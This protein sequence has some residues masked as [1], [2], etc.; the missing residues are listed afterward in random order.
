MDRDSSCAEAGEE[1]H[2]GRIDWWTV[3]LGVATLTIVAATAWLRFGPSPRPEPPAVGSALPPLRLISL[4][5][6]EPLLLLGPKGKVVWV[7][8]WSAG[9]ASGRECLPR[10]E[11]AW[12][13]LRP[14]ARF[15]MVAAAVDSSQ[16]DHVRTTITGARSSLPVY[17]APPETC[18]RFGVAGAD[19][20]LH[21]LIDPQGKIAALAR[22]SG[23]DTID[24]LASQAR[25]WLDE[26]DPLRNTRFAAAGSP[27]ATRSA[28]FP[29]GNSVVALRA[30]R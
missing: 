4:E 11:D 30:G 1:V 22:G 29:T 17:L 6:A 26:L 28:S 12:K 8:F 14:H 19:P 15:A 21:L 20:P 10:L 7:V 25:S 3:F 5:N 13:R 24:R 9:S 16:P 18:R 23:Q 2:P 27:W